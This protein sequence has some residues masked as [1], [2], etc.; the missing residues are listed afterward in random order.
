LQAQG[1]T[2]ALKLRHDFRVDSRTRLELG[3]DV[4]LADEQ[5]LSK[6]LQ[7][8]APWA[9]VLYQASPLLLTA[10][11][12]GYFAVAAAQQ[13]SSAVLASDSGLPCP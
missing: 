5:G 3:L 9:S 10:T 1:C 12:T 4:T 13:R 6:T 11:T 8:A 7:S 2:H